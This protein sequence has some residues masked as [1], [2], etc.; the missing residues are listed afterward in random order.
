MSAQEWT[1]AEASNDPICRS[2]SPSSPQEERNEVMARQLS[3]RLLQEEYNHNHNAPSSDSDLCM[4]QQL[5]DKELARRFSRIEELQATTSTFLD[6]HRSSTN[7]I[8]INTRDEDEATMNACR[9]AREMEDAEMAQRLSVY[10]QEAASRREIAHQRTP[11]ARRL[12]VFSRV[13]DDSWQTNFRT[14][15]ANWDA[16]APT[17]IDSL[18]LR[19]TRIDYEIECLAVTGKMKVCNANYGPT[20][21]FEQSLIES[22]RQSNCQFL[23][24]DEQILLA[25]R[26]Q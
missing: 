17:G 26:K 9:I 22:S 8:N 10:E 25:T 2:R 16:G 21:W 23:D 4:A 13:L 20:Q 11:Q 12:T 1:L 15:V 6:E 18:T 24:Q 19:V 14:A 7:N 3:Q 5:Q